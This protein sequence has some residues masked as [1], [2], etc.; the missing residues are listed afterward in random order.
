M[1]QQHIKKH[2]NSFS[3]DNMVMLS[4]VNEWLG[5][6]V[7]EAIDILKVDPALNQDKGRYKPPKVY[8]K[9]LP[10]PGGEGS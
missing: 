3:L 2:K 7:Q 9:I 10:D 6:G 5:C 4:H 1:V 8:N